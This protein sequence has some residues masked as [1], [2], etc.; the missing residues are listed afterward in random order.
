MPTTSTIDLILCSDRHQFLAIPSV[1]RSVV[2]NAAHPEAIS[3]HLVALPEE[4]EELRIFMGSEFPDP[5]FRYRVVEFT[6]HTAIMQRYIRT[7]RS[8]P[9]SRSHIPRR[10]SE[11]NCSRFYLSEILPDLD[12]I[13]YL[14]TDLIVQR[15]IAQL[16]READLSQHSL[17]GVSIGNWEVY[18]FHPDSEHFRD[19]DLSRPAF[20]NGM[21]AA[22][23]AKWRELDLVSR[24]EYWMEA[25][26][27]FHDEHGEVLFC[28]GSQTLMNAALGGEFLHLDQGWNLWGLGF[29]DEYSKETLAEAG[30]LHWTGPGKP[31]KPDGLYKEYWLPYSEP[32]RRLI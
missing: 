23:L 17:A 26:S 31:W 32:L 9:E 28:Y 20:N 30:I 19:I 16:D 15:D 24:F 25:W 6:S 8:T 3:F 29:G 12:K 18:V 11:I 22:S 13:I 10:A 1:M 7:A 4:S 5:V 2:R 21:F 27:N 14:D